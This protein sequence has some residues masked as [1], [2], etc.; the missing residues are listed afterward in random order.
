MTTYSSTVSGMNS[1]INGVIHEKN[2]R[3]P[4]EKYRKRNQAIPSRVKGAIVI[5]RYEFQPQ[6]IKTR[7]PQQQLQMQQLQRRDPN[8]P[9]LTGSINTRD[10]KDI[11]RKTNLDPS[12][13]SSHMDSS[14]IYAQSILHS[15]SGLCDIPVNCYILGDKNGLKG[16]AIPLVKLMD[17]VSGAVSILVIP[18]FILQHYIF[19]EVSFHREIHQALMEL[20]DKDPYFV[21]L[22]SKII[23][24]RLGAELSKKCRELAMHF[25]NQVISGGVLAYTL[26]GVDYGEGSGGC[27]L[28]K[29]E[30]RRRWNG[31]M[32]PY[33]V[34]DMTMRS[35][36]NALREP[37]ADP[38]Y[39]Q[40][41]WSLDYIVA[42]LV[43]L[44]GS[45]MDRTYLGITI[46]KLV[47]LTHCA[48]AFPTDQSTID[49]FCQHVLKCSTSDD[50]HLLSF[51]HGGTLKQ[52]GLSH[53]SPISGYHAGRDM[54]LTLNVARFKYPP[55][56]VLVQLFWQAMHKVDEATMQ[57]RGLMLIS[58]PHV[59]S[60][61]LNTMS[62]GH[63]S[64]ASVAKYLVDEGPLLLK[65]GDVKD[66]SNLF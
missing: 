58:R 25:E 11:K 23:N 62:C 8:H 56:C 55:H 12:Q 3:L 38:L 39:L 66:I 18:W 63:E 28:L 14:C 17:E 44:N 13:K 64:W 53:F 48:G 2:R 37:F 35:V 50:C 43:A 4:T 21:G 65:L 20:G 6:Q 40:Y 5:G 7:E 10:P 9:P 26:L 47:C 42:L 33:W 46:G 19:I 51:Y 24:A 45:S 22:T 61:L 41:I 34:F 57:H 15:K 54:T 59:E 32:L 30:L 27:A 16:G 52:T 60:G 49:D 29:V 36:G 31:A 1:A